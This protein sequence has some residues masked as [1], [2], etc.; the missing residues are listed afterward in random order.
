[1]LDVYSNTSLKV[2]QD[3][4]TTIEPGCYDALV[5]SWP[6]AIVKH[7]YGIKLKMD[8]YNYRVEG[9]RKW[10][11]DL[12]SHPTDPILN[13]IVLESYHNVT[14]RMVADWCRLKRGDGTC[15][16]KEI[17]CPFLLPFTIEDFQIF[18]VAAGT[19]TTTIRLLNMQAQDSGFKDIGILISQG[20]TDMYLHDLDE[21]MGSVQTYLPN[22]EAMVISLHVFSEDAE[23]LLPPPA[24]GPYTMTMKMITFNIH[25]YRTLPQSGIS[26]ILVYVASYMACLGQANDCD[27]SIVLHHGGG[28]HRSFWGQQ[29]VTQKIQPAR[30]VPLIKKLQSAREALESKKPSIGNGNHQ[31][32]LQSET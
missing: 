7:N 5:A 14:L 11:D 32:S 23:I 29:E 26:D 9:T 21:V 3:G 8:W 27:Y 13:R 28:G 30:Y 16:F 1:M 6:G 31:I 4:T 24:K 25:S 2:D 20:Q 17:E 22:L 18:V 19:D 12:A 10:L 15:S